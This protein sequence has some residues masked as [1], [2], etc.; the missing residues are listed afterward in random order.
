M[1]LF[2]RCSRA[3]TCDCSV[4]AAVLKVHGLGRVPEVTA[5]P[6]NTPNMDSY[7]QRGGE[8]L[9]LDGLESR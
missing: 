8:Q 2:C 7:G 5:N 4:L 1:C 6:A 3:E 9:P